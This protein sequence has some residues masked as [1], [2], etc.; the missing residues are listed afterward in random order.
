M[1][2]GEIDEVVRGI[3]FFS[4][5]GPGRSTEEGFWVEDKQT[6]QPKKERKNEGRYGSDTHAGRQRRS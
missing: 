5:D 3:G 4:S 6:M 2:F 1:A